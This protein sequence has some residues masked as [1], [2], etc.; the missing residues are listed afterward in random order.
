MCLR[1]AGRL[2]YDQLGSGM[3]AA[4]MVNWLVGLAIDHAS[5]WHGVVQS[6]VEEVVVLATL[7]ALGLLSLTTYLE[8][9]LDFMGV[10]ARREGWEALCFAL[11]VRLK[12]AFLLDARGP[13][14]PR[15]TW[16][17]LTW[18]VAGRRRRCLA[19]LVAAGSSWHGP[20]PPSSE[21]SR[22]E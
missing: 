9:E 4:F 20:T 14:C 17:P 7:E 15:R 16:A 18:C 10:Q 2:I 13:L 6:F 3:E 11:A 19:R 1:T 8:R 22:S 5:Q 12:T 21:L